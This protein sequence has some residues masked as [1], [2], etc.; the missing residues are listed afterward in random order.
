MNMG[1]FIEFLES[2]EEK[3]VELLRDKEDIDRYKRKLRYVFYKESLI[4]AEI[5]QKGLA[6]SF[7]L[8]E[9]NYETKLKDAEDF[10]R[11]SKIEL[12]KESFDKCAKCIK[13]NELNAKLQEQYGI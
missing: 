1:G 10:A 9:L 2:F 5:L 3:E 13:L 8:D 4:N 7:M 6:T 12:W 11:N